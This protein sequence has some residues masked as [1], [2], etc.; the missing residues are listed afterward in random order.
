MK[1]ILG[2]EKTDWALGRRFDSKTNYVTPFW[3]L[4]SFFSYICN[5]FGSQ[6]SASVTKQLV[7]NGVMAGYVTLR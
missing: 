7:Y 2:L 5:L 6:H 4:F 3:V 1:P